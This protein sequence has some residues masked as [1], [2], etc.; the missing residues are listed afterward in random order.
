MSD[1]FRYALDAAVCHF[2]T[3]SQFSQDQPRETEFHDGK[4]PGEFAPKD[5]PSIQSAKDGRTDFGGHLTRLVDLINEHREGDVPK[6]QHE[7]AKSSLS[8][9]GGAKSHLLEY[10]HADRDGKTDDSHPPFSSDEEKSAVRE[11][12]YGMNTK[13]VKS[14]KKLN[15]SHPAVKFALDLHSEL[16]KLNDAV[17]AMKDRVVTATQQREAK[18]EAAVRAEKAKP[19]T[20][21]SKI[22]TEA[23]ETL[24]PQMQSFFRHV[25]TQRL[26]SLNRMVKSYSSEEPPK[27]IGVGFTKEYR[28]AM[29]ARDNKWKAIQGVFSELRKCLNPDAAA[30]DGGHE[31]D[32][33]RLE[34]QAD[35]YATNVLAAMRSKINQKLEDLDD[36]SFQHASGSETHSACMAPATERRSRY[37][38]ASNGTS[39]LSGL[40]SISTPR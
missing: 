24:R 34:Q 11:A 21:L 5:F 13:A 8:W 20:T 25:M 18:K 33:K 6:K 40:H 4:K 1:S 3:E 35:Q 27:S 39:R 10:M 17:K 29:Q 14:L 16:T 22:V 30:M 15:S 31:L 32:T 28:E 23:T 36:A 26:E 2:A 37:S 7:K 12:Y 19:V 38:R 9:L